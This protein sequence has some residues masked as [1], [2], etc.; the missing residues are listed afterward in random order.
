MGYRNC[1]CKYIFI[2]IYNLLILY[3][4]KSIFK[5]NKERRKDGKEEKNNTVTFILI[6]IK[7]YFLFDFLNK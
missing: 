1:W 7:K 3:Q 5:R 4:Y 6:F 2:N